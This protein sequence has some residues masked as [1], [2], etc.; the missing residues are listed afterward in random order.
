VTRGE[1]AKKREENEAEFARIV[2]FSD[3]VFA[4]AITLLV[5]ALNIPAHLQGES[6]AEALWDQRQQFLA[7]GISFAVIGRYWVLHH[8]FFSE[9]TGFDSRLLSLN[10]FYL[11]WIV[12][13]PFSSE[14]LGEHGSETAGIIVYALNLT[15]V[16]L[17]GW[18]LAADAHRAG[19]TRLKVEDAR[20]YRARS[21]F[22]ALVFLASVPVAF[23]APSF[24][25]FLWLALWLDPAGRLGIGKPKR[26]N[27]GTYLGARYSGGTKRIEWPGSAQ[28]TAAFCPCRAAMQ[29]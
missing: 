19:L 12:L 23:L 20:E 15:A 4:I 7:Y 3:G 17:V 18:W 9:V 6:V 11:A 1:A 24:A 13:I 16:A 14:V 21:F 5:L 28:L 29:R 26:S 25:P 27:G 22:V 8:R 10:L 2:A